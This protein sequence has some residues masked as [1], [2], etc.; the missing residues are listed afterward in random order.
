LLIMLCLKKNYKKLNVKKII[1]LRIT[2]ILLIISY[3][4]YQNIYINS[5]IYNSVGNTSNINIWISTR[6]SQ[7]RGLIYPFIYSS[8]EI[9]DSKPAGYNEEEA[10][11][12][13]NNYTY[14]NIPEDKK[15]NIIAIMLEAY[16]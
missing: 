13:L 16:N 7:I 15:V 4:T 11:E 14:E 5:E 9:L 10:K 8:T 6:Q 12:I 3:F 1:T 2:I